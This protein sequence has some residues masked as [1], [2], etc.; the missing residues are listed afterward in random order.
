MNG[1]SNYKHFGPQI[2]GMFNN[3]VSDDTSSDGTTWS[4]IL[5]GFKIEGGD[6][7]GKPL[8]PV[9]RTSNVGS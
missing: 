8:T 9:L 7:H 2:S 6:L 3:L 1:Y 4:E 5:D